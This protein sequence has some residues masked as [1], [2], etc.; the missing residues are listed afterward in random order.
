MA[1]Q[2]TVCRFKIRKS[3][4]PDEFE[5]SLEQLRLRVELGVLVELEQRAAVGLQALARRHRIDGADVPA[6]ARGAHVAHRRNR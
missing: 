3:A 6:R 2:V 4:D 5:K 1:S